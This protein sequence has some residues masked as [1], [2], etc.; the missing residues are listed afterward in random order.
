MNNHIIAEIT[1]IISISNLQ[2][3]SNNMSNPGLRTRL[4]KA[5]EAK[6]KQKAKPNKTY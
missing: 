1:Q 4:K 3:I 6:Q 5:K 2:L